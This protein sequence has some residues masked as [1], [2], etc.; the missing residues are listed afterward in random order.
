MEPAKLGPKRQNRSHDEHDR[1]TQRIGGRIRRTRVVS[2]FGLGPSRRKYFAQRSDRTFEFP[3]V[4]CAAHSPQIP[5]PETEYRCFCV[6]RTGIL[7]LRFPIRRFASHLEQLVATKRRCWR[8]PYQDLLT[9]TDGKRTEDGQTNKQKH[10]GNR[11]RSIERNVHAREADI[12]G[13]HASRVD[14]PQRLFAQ[15]ARYVNGART[16]IPVTS[17]KRQYNSLLRARPT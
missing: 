1:G 16:T 8:G 3:E 9:W 17:S 5:K 15:L 11:T 10:E 2:F 13:L 6:Y 4:T 7:T 12:L 14:L